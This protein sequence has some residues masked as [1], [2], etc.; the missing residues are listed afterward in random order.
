MNRSNRI[1]NNCASGSSDCSGSYL[2]GGGWGS[3]SNNSSGS[4]NST[5]SST[6]NSTTKNSNDGSSSNC[7]VFSAKP[8]I[9]QFKSNPCLED[10]LKSAIYSW[11]S[12]H[13]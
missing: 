4:D 6:Y 1:G 9:S 5:H 12:F 7:Y 10:L 8:T 3:N 11:N 2:S 13:H